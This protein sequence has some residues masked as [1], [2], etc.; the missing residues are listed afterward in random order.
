MFDSLLT[1]RRRD[2]PQS[3]RELAALAAGSPLKARPVEHQRTF[4]WVR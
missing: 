2:G 4:G 3:A 1:S